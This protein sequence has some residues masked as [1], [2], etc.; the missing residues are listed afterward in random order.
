MLIFVVYDISR[1]PVPATVVYITV[2]RVD[3][4]EVV[5]DNS[6]SV[7]PIVHSVS[8]DRLRGEENR[9]YEVIVEVENIQGNST[10]ISNFF[11]VNG[12]V[13]KSVCTDRG[14]LAIQDSNYAS[15]HYRVPK[16][17]ETSCTTC[18]PV[19]VIIALLILTT[20]TDRAFMIILFA[21]Y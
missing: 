13:G 10:P 18:L 20:I 6:S 21:M 15:K 2:R 1:N 4:M 5:W 19:H 3:T 9:R 7:E 12:A 16:P 8:L 11:N 17:P 14:G